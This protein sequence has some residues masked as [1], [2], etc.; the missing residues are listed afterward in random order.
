[1]YICTRLSAIFID[2]LHFISCIYYN[3]NTYKIWTEDKYTVSLIKKIRPRQVH[4]TAVAT[5]TKVAIAK[6]L[7]KVAACLFAN[8]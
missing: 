6:V 4:F 1:M 5:E 2:V 3:Y 7:S 8:N